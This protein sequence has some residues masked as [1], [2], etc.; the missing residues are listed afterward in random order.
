MWR[1]TM[2]S[3]FGGGKFKRLLRGPMWSSCERDDMGDP[4]KVNIRNIF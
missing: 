1:E 3:E 2:E 4:Q